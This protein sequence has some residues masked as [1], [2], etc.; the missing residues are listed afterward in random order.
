MTFK[1][2]RDIVRQMER[3]MQMISDD[4]FR[5]FF[6]L[7]VSGGRFW[8]PPVDIHE[9]EDTLLVKCEIAGVKA[10]DLQVALS[11]DD[12]ILTI[13]GMRKESQTERDG[14]TRCHQIEIYF[15]PFE[16]AVTLPQGVSVDRD[17]LSAM[18]KDGFLIVTLPKIE[19]VEEKTLRVIPITSEPD[20]KIDESGDTE[21]P[22]AAIKPGGHVR[23]IVNTIR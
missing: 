3:D 11:A 18:Y 14:R 4:L 5:G 21:S 9:T 2:Y 15:G 16:R 20:T 7:P 22:A 17:K 1:D 13:A 10:E 23:A 12:K 6:D 19:H 8:V